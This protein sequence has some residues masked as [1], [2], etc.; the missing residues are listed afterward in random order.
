MTLPRCAILHLIDTG[1]PGGAE[2]IFARLATHFDTRARS[3]AVIPSDK[4]LASELRRG[5]I[6]P[7]VMPAHGSMELGYLGKLRSL[8]RDHDVRLIQTH[9]LGSAVYGSLAALGTGIP[10]VCVFHGPTD[11]RNPGR[12]AALK[13]R[14][15]SHTAAAIVAVSASTRQELNDFGLPDTA[16]TQINNGIDTR[17][18]YPGV[19]DSIRARLQLQPGDILVGAVGNIRAPKAYE[20]LLQAA[21][22]V[23]RVHPNVHFAVIGQEDKNLM[24]ALLTS[25]DRL[26]LASRFHFLGFVRS[27]RQ[28]YNN[29]D[30]FV[31]SSRSEGLSLSFLEAMATA[32]PIVATC[33]GG[34]QQAIVDR[35]SGL[36]VPVD[37]PEALA[38][39]LAALI[40]DPDLR[41][42]L[43]RGARSRCTAE[44]SL[45]RMFAAYEAIYERCSPG[46]L[47]PA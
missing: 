33:S 10:A 37:A 36:L 12:V 38:D 18:F 11:L 45:E 8:I 34:A 32:R 24:P 4:W 17:E 44:F 9:L 46:T 29:F 13:R 23:A 40:I 42:R 28:L 21:A 27:D 31:S 7:I 6:E 26:G 20:V 22:A 16:I 1:G 41:S 25:R 14:L 39:S 19:S 30:V 35:I 5:G 43:A 2:T 3:L 47:Q 15:L